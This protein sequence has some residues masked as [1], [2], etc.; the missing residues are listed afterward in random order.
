MSSEP[1]AALEAELVRMLLAEFGARAIYGRLG[2]AV[3]DVQLSSLLRAFEQ[4]QRAQIDATRRLIELCGFRSP[5]DS[6]RRRALA[7]ALASLRVV[8]GQRLILRLCA[9]AERTRAVGYSQLAEHFARNAPTELALLAQ[10]CATRSA[11][12]ADALDAWVALA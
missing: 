5:S 2:S 12:H 8:L 6:L 11:R 9:D 4:E 10:A 1:S 7:H 3:R